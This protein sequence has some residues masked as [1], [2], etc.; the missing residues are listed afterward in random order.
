MKEKYF[1]IA[2]TNKAGSTSL[3]EWIAAH[4]SICPSFI[5]Q[6]FFFLDKNWQQSF[7]LHSL[8]DYKNGF[9][10][11]D[12]FFRDHQPGQHK[13]EASPEYM[14]APAT[15]K[16]IYDFLNNKEGEVIFILRNPAARFISL[17]YFGIQQGVIDPA[18]SF[19]EFIQACENYHANNNTS[20]KALETGFYSKYLKKY[21]EVFGKNKLRI[22]FFE[23]LINNPLSFMKRVA[24]DLGIDDSFYNDYEFRAYNQ[25]KI[26]VKNRAIAGLYRTTR[27]LF[28]QSSYK[29]KTGYLLASILKKGII[30]IYRKLNTAQLKKQPIS[31]KDKEYVEQIYQDEKLKIEKMFGIQVPW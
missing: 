29:T 28:I 10:Q 23:D 24:K 31:N 25:T 27:N 1:I 6:T 5:K 15:P 26:A 9:H 19:S 3:F 18:W 8:Y 30:P 7:K 22:Y 20:L 14:Y 4:P 2:G 11:F 13:I 21:K 12:N 17:Y 16:R